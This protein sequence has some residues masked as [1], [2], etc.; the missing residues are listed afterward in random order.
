M[1]TLRALVGGSFLLI[2]VGLVI[3]STLVW[4]LILS[5]GQT[6]PEMLIKG[7]PYQWNNAPV[8]K[9]ILPRTT[10]EQSRYKLEA[11]QE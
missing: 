2:V 11:K 8:Q 9:R 1:T 3:S 6:H 5:I 10:D 7:Q 4:T